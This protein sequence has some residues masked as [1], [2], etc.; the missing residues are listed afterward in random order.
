MKCSRKLSLTKWLRV[1]ALMIALAVV[2]CAREPDAEALLR[3]MSEMEAALEAG[4]T[5]D[6]L[7]RFS[8]DFSGQGAELNRQQL[9][10]TLV[11]LKFR[12][13]NIGVTAGAPEIKLFGDRATV[14]VQVLAT[15]GS[16]MPETGQMLEIES[17]WRRED[18]E[19]K[20]F[21]ASWQGKW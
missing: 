20:C 17:S 11:G 14:R 6:F 18:G 4:E 15:G 8:A 12:H 3:S 13:E 5:N 7:D 9:R 21:A 2:G 1:A 19:W 16:W 10:A